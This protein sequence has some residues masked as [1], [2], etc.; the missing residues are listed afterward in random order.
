TVPDDGPA[1]VAGVSACE[2]VQLFVERAARARAGFALSERNAAAVA[3]ICRRLD[4]IP[5]AIELAAARARVFAPAQIAEGLSERF[6]L[7]T[8]GIRTALPRQ[9]TLEASVDWSHDLLTDVERTVLRR[10]SVFAGGF[11]FEAA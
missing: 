3:D 8:G 5:L 6:R 7:L 11:S 4:G 9:Q 2:A 10:L 1:G